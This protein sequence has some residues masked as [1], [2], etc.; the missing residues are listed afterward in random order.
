MTY[1]IYEGLFEKVEKKLNSISKKCA[2]YGNPFT[3]EIVGDKVETGKD[4]DG[5][6]V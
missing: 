6:E 1:E 3:F 5:N 4:E 2:K